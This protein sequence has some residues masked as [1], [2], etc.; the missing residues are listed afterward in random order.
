[1]YE[2]VDLMT[3]GLRKWSLEENRPYATTSDFER[4]YTGGIRTQLLHISTTKRKT[5]DDY[6]TNK[7]LSAFAENHA[8][9]QADI[10][11]TEAMHYLAALFELVGHTEGRLYCER[12]K[13]LL[14]SLQTD[15]GVICLADI[16]WCE[17]KP[18]T[19]KKSNNTK[20]AS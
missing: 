15:Y 10:A 8:P 3:E 20:T 19:S 7:A 12:Q 5:I 17:K 13:K 9:G 6:I 18:S 16:R 2:Y 4:K 14:D 1:M 11:R